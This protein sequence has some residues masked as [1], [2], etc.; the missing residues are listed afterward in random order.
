MR[1]EPC[2]VREARTTRA[3]KYAECW[4]EVK[5]RATVGGTLPAGTRYQLSEKSIG[6]VGGIEVSAAVT[7]VLD[8]AIVRGW[9][10]RRSFRIFVSKGGS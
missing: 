6:L 9:N 4:R 10:K 8:G 1:E 5:S 7:A 3:G 2:T